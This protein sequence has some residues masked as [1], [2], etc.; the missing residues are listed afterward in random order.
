MGTSR[1][2][3]ALALAFVLVATAPLAAA[4]SSA[5]PIA[6]MSSSPTSP[7]TP[8]TAA[9]ANPLPSFGDKDLATVVVATTNVAELAAAV[10][11]LTGV[12][13]RAPKSSG[14]G[15]PLLTIPR[16]MIEAIQ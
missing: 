15:T 4:H 3:F 8:P 6:T 11:K 13:I 9:E 7:P 16:G 1:A 12:P 2:L 14:F 10:S 5:T